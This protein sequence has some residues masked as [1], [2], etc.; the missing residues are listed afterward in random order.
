METGDWVLL[1]LV[2][3]QPEGIVITREEM[4]QAVYV[5]GKDALEVTIDE[6]GSIHINLKPVT[7]SGEVVTDLPAIE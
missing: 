6:M 1:A 4:T 7:L 2:A 5:H 3:R